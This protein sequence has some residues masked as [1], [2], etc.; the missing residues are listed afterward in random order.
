VESRIVQSGKQL[1]Q[2]LIESLT[3]LN[4]KLQGETPAAEDLWDRIGTGIFRPKGELHLSNYIKRHFDAD[5]RERGIIANR[6]VEIRQGTGGAQGER[7]DVK[8]DAI[9][10][11]AAG[12]RIDVVTVIVEVKGCWN[13]GVSKDMQLQLSDRYL[14]DNP[15]SDGLYVVG[16][17]RCRQWRDS[18]CVWPATTTYEDSVKALEDQALRLTTDQQ[19][20]RSFVVNASLR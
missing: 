14:R 6:E 18:D 3:R 1:V 5:I 8:V 7:T 4:V 9:V 15:S 12:G 17:F 16:W 20:I 13:P 11:D 10:T 19:M 2:V